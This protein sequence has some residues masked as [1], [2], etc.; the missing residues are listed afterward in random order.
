MMNRLIRKSVLVAAL[1]TAGVAASQASGEVVTSKA[2]PVNV[3]PLAQ[4]EH[5]WGMTYLPDGKLLI[6]E[7]PGRLRIFEGGKLSEPV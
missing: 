3:E 1:V 5:P 4:L 6:T 2:G 7:K